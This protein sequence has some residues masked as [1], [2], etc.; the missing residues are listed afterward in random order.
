MEKWVV[1][2][3]KA[4]FQEIGK[5]FGVDPVIARRPRICTERWYIFMENC[6][7]SIPGNC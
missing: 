2:A 3:K 7:V 1:S 5:K 4:D 6:P